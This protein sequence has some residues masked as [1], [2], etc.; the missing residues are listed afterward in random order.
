M[1]HC[2]ASAACNTCCWVAPLEITNIPT[3]VHAGMIDLSDRLFI[4]AAKGDAAEL[5]AVLAAGADP[6]CRHST[7]SPL[8]SAAN[9]GSAECVR[10]LISAGADPNRAICTDFNRA[11]QL[12]HTPLLPAVHH[13]HSACCAA[14]LAGGAQFR[15]KKAT[16]WTLLH[17][18]VMQDAD[19]CLSQLL[20]AA[21]DA[22][23]AKDEL[24]RTPLRLA[25]LCG[26]TWAARMLMLE[27]PL[28]PAGQLLSLL[29]E[30]AAD[31]SL[32]AALA[33]R[34]PLTAAQWAALPCPCA[35]LGDALPA[36]LGRSAEEARLLVQRLPPREQERLQAA[37]LSLGRAQRRHGVHLPIPLQW[38]LLALGAG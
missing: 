12:L 11:S 27:G 22:A 36:V 15:P 1:C 20:A 25:L 2:A 5:S 8:W 10:L 37:A 16:D 26:R 14:L 4:A 19:A 38:R 21:P 29:S 9:A 24:G 6:E 31:H 35:T 30:Y 34:Q 7:V 28:Q 17:A 23:L 3:L 33:A 32:Y 13:N 18:A